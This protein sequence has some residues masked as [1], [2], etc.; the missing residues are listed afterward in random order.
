MEDGSPIGKLFA[1]SLA[2]RTTRGNSRCSV[3]IA[4][5]LPLRHSVGLLPSPFGLGGV[6]LANEL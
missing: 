1:I 2:P 6:L 3:N 5:S 4:G